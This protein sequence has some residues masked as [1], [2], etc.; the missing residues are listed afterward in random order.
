LPSY[1]IFFS[2]HAEKAITQIARYEP[3]LYRRL[4]NA[5][6]ALEKDPLFGKAL[7]GQLKGHYSYRVG[8]YRIVYR[9]HHQKLL[10]IVID[11]GHR[12]EI[13]Q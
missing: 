10:V 4:A 2:S 11:V 8:S 3:I 7:K 13:Y 9:I 5:L 1:K 6:D 12:R